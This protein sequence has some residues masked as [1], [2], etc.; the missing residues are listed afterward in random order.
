MMVERGDFEVVHEPF[1]HV[2]D[3][4]V[5][6]VADREARSEFE[7]IAALRDLSRERRVFFKDTTD[8][9]YPVVL[10]EASFLREAV[11]TFMIRDPR[12]AI[13][14][15]HRLEPG[16]DRNA[17]GFAWL[18]ELFAAV[19]LASQSE[20][21]VVDADD[22]LSAPQAVVSEYCR[23]VQIRFMPRSLTW[24]PRELPEWR[25]TARWHSS[26]STST[27]FWKLE[28]TETSDVDWNP[29]LQ[30]FLDYHAPFYEKMRAVRLR[31]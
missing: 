5:A 8:F 31:V 27:G 21:I 6:R 1:S 7:V 2:A 28:S 24:L 4:G 3:F 23:R 14:S 29:Q 13:V 20:P 19:R 18:Y 16:L 9:R 30:S 12:A 22:L 15:H 11:H 10:A 26:V 17:I 25:R